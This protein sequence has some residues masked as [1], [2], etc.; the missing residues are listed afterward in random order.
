MNMWD[1][2]RAAWHL[3]QLFF[4]VVRLPIGGI[5]SP[6]L[7]DNLFL[8]I[9]DALYLSLYTGYLNNDPKN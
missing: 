8:F 2:W 5:I 6:M 9:S 3:H 7:H 4:S 1:F